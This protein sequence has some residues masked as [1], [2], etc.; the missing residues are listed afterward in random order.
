MSRLYC[1]TCGRHYRDLS[2]LPEL[3]KRAAEQAAIGNYWAGK[4]LWL[5]ELVTEYEADLGCDYCQQRTT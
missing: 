2:K 1:Q 5:A 3:R 4:A